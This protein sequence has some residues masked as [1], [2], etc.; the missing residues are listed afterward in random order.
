M[1]AA[2]IENGRVNNSSDVRLVQDGRILLGAYGITAPT[3]ADWDP[4]TDL[5]GGIRFDLG[6]YGEDGF[7]LTPEPGDNKNFKAHNEDVVIDIDG[8]GTWA[9]AFSGIQRSKTLVEAYFDT[10][11]DSATG[12]LLLTKASVNTYR[13]LIT[14]GISGD[15]VILTHYARVKVADREALTYGATAINAFGLTFR[16][17][18]DPVLGY[19]ADLCCGGCSDDLSGVSCNY[20]GCRRKRRYH[21]YW[22]HWRFRGEVRYCGCVV[23]HHQL[24]DSDHCRNACWSGWFGEHHGHERW[25][26]FHRVHLRAQ[27][28]HA[29]TPV[30]TRG[31][32]VPTG[33]TL[34]L[35]TLKGC[36]NGSDHP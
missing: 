13:D 22:V 34:L 27:L 8:P 32:H 1:A 4:A 9:A 18:K 15:D 20:T 31:N 7:T 17:Y 16:A 21:W 28:R 12:K 19:I 10:T 3:G 5:A 36:L 24:G 25:R 30:G 23:V 6:Y 11:V 29:Q 35:P 2:L 33:S 26:S 14:V